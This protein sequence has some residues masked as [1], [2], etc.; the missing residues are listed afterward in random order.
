VD[1][2]WKQGIFHRVLGVLRAMKCA[3]SGQSSMVIL[4]PCRDAKESPQGSSRIV[5]DT[6]SV[7]V[8]IEPCASSKIVPPASR[9][10]SALARGAN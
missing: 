2:M 4:E 8:A 5:P 3:I 1:T 9:P 7:V 10:R 6:F